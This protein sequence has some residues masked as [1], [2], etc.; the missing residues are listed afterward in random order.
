LTAIT[1]DVSPD[2]RL[3]YDVSA[4]WAL[5]LDAYDDFGPLRDFCGREQTR[6]LFGVV[7][8]NGKPVS[9]ECGVGVGLNAA[10][11]GVTLKL[12][13]SRDL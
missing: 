6:Q 11:D 13:L 4:L 7:D 2:T 3:A 1:V 9:V 5:A 12:I 10:T 8:F